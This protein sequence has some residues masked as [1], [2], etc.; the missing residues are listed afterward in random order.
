MSNL[1]TLA[2]EYI[3]LFA[4]KNLIGL[5]D[6]FDENIKLLDWENEIEG[7]NELIN[8]NAKLFMN[9][10]HIEIDILNIVADK[11]LVFIEMIINLDKKIVL[12]V[13]DIIKFSKKNKIIMIKAYKA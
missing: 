12:K 1:K 9:F 2:S 4:Q 3:Y 13:V 8:F 7:R 11:N 6:L 10:E 5:K